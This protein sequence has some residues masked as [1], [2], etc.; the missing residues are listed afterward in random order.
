MTVSSGAHAKI[1]RSRGVTETVS[2]RK[3]PFEHAEPGDGQ[4]LL[5]PVDAAD[6]DPGLRRLGGAL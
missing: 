2:P 6:D 4:R 3:I 1:S 5:Q